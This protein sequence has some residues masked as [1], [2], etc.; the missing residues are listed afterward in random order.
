MMFSDGEANS[1]RQ[2]RRAE[3]RQ[4]CLL[5]SI[6]PS[7]LPTRTLVRDSLE[8]LAFPGLMITQ[9]PS[10]ASQVRRSN[11][12]LVRLPFANLFLV[13]PTHYHSRPVLT[14][15]RR[16][17]ISAMRSMSAL[18]LLISISSIAPDNCFRNDFAPRLLE[19]MQ[20]SIALLCDGTLAF[21][22]KGKAKLP[23][24]MYEVRDVPSRLG[25]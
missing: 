14:K 16:P 22:V 6:N 5:D 10:R 23:W 4:V 11:P 3:M 25:H 24:A 2:L 12:L 18:S 17:S 7:C 21:G 9:S 15:V 19:S 20:T 13:H 1:W 8:H